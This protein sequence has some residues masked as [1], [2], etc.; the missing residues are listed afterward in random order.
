MS[1]SEFALSAITLNQEMT[2]IYSSD[3]PEVI[4]IDYIQKKSYADFW[5][6][7]EKGSC[8]VIC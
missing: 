2:V 3:M 1:K 8:G 5:C 6:M 4:T 7:E